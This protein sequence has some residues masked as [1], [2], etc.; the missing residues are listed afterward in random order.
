MDWVPFPTAHSP[1]TACRDAGLNARLLARLVQGLYGR[2]IHSLILI[3][4]GVRVLDLSVPPY[5]NRIV[6]DVHS[7]AKAFT[8]IACGFAIQEGR[9]DLST[10]IVELL[11]AN[12]AKRSDAV[13][14]LTIYHLLTMTAGQ[15]PE[16]FQ[17]IWG[18]QY[19][20]SAFLSTPITIE[21]GTTFEY[22]NFCS[23]VLSAV[24]QRVTGRRLLD[25]LGP[26]LFDRLEIRERHW[27]Q[28]GK[29]IDWGASGL[30]ISVESMACF[31]YFL[32]NRGMWDGHQLL[33][34]D[35]IDLMG[36]KQV[37]SY[38]QEVPAWIEDNQGYGF[39]VWK[40]SFGG[41]RASGAYQQEI[42]VLPDHHLTASFSGGV[43]DLEWE[44][45][46][47]FSSYVIPACERGY[48]GGD[49]NLAEAVDKFEKPL[50]CDPT[51]HFNSAVPLRM[52]HLEHPVIRWRTF[53]IDLHIEGIGVEH[54]E[55]KTFVT[56][57]NHG[58]PVRLEC[59]RKGTYVVGKMEYGIN[60]QT[61][62]L[63]P[64]V[65]GSWIDNKTYE[66]IFRPLTRKMWMIF[67]VRFLC[68]SAIEL[69]VSLDK[70]HGVDPETVRGKA[71]A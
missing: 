15:R 24:I 52:Y 46:S 39:Q 51:A 42:V 44:P 58:V 55:G 50:G 1:D 38:R 26:R 54:I 13:D 9:F 4:D 59:G 70:R 30:Y 6:Q 48:S 28:L 34:A 62:D 23:F 35:F 56:L 37:N 21:P 32:L 65:C 36:S 3:K 20:V 7:A 49:E 25:Y 22:N 53:H 69:T 16:D 29:G 33:R 8:A 68:P 19:W 14:R 63:K 17:K 47:L 66:F 43:V 5:S 27:E 40:N 45:L 2:E 10:P 61:F 41:F 60:G 12:P 31:G 11:D 71:T 57:V 67:T 18:Q 64:A